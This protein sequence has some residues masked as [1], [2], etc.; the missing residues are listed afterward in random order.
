MMAALSFLSMSLSVKLA[1]DFFANH[2]RTA[3]VCVC[4]CVCG[5]CKQVRENHQHII[6]VLHSIHLREEL[7]QNTISHG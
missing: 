2:T 4:V 5:V 3:G 7:G 1:K 6:E